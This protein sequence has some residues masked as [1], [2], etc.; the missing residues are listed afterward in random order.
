MR[1]SIALR[2]NKSTTAQAQLFFSVY[3]MRSSYAPHGQVET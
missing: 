2:E 3:S 1:F